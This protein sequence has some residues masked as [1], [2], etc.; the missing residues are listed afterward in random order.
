L[1]CSSSYSISGLVSLQ[2][3]QTHKLF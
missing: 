3:S 2:V 1:E